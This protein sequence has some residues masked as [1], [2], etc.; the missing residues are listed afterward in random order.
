MQGLTLRGVLPLQSNDE[1]AKRHAHARPDPVAGKK[2]PGLSCV[3]LDEGTEG[4]GK[5][6]PTYNKVKR[7]AQ[8]LWGLT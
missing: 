6:V 5:E 8:W 3:R 4:Q 2:S 1:R 7:S